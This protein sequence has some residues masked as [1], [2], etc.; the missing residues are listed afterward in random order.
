M[1]NYQQLNLKKKPTKQ[2][3]RTGTESQIGRLFGELAVGSGKRKNGEKGTGI[4]KYK[5]VGTKQIAGC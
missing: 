4:K 1:H 2:T 5:L 3:T